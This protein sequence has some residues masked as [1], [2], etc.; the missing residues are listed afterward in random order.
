[1]RLLFAVLLALSAAPALAAEWG[2][3][4][5]ER[6]GVEADVPPGFGADEPSAN[7]DGQRFSTPTARLAIYGSL[8]DEGDFES[9]VA[10]RQQWTETDGWN[11]TYQ[12]RSPS[13]AI[14]SG[15]RGSRILYA[16]AIRICDGNVLGAFELEYSEADRVAFDAV[17]ERLARS[18]RDTGAGWQC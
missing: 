3:Y 9:A 15:K 10:Q 5:N 14:W 7:G 8:I 12:A 18:L 11:I 4:V 17:V 2:H 13:W 16:R 6:F 1:M